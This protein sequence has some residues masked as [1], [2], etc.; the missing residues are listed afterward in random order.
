[1]FYYFPSKDLC[2]NTKHIVSVKYEPL[3]DTHT[4]PEDGETIFGH[5]P[6]VYITILSHDIE[7]SSHYDG[8]IFAASTKSDV[9]LV[10]GDEAEQLVFALKRG[11]LD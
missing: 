5:P 6:R 3:V 8:E 7:T 1:M 2:I 9:I 4:D 11:L 10:A